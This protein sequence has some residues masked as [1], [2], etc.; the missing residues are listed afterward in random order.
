MNFNSESLSAVETHSNQSP[1]RTGTQSIERVVS[2]I[3][4]VASRGRSGM[5]I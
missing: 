3:R 5:R 2:M 1:Q 4:V